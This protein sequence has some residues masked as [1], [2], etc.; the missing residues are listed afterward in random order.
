VNA[1]D[2]LKYGHQTV[3][4]TL[5]RLPHEVWTTPNVCGVWSTKDIVA[6]LASFEQ[7][8][9][10]VLSSLMDTKHLTPMLDKFRSEATFNDSQV[11]ARKDS[12]AAEVLAEYESS[13]A[14]VAARAV[15]PDL[16][17]QPGTLP[18]YGEEYSLDDLIVYMFYGHKREHSAQLALF[19]KSVN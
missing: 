4:S 19:R 7:V 12:S 18:W 5:D 8:L 3:L 6:H 2:V 1:H 11:A 14:R 16:F 9:D 15:P 10:E 13:Y 17:S